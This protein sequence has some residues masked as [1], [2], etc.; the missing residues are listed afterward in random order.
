MEFRVAAAG[1]LVT[2]VVIVVCVVAGRLA[3]DSNHFFDVAVGTSGGARRTPPGARVARLDG[4]DQRAGAR[5]QP[6][7][8]LP[9]GRRPDRPRRDLVADRRPQPRDPRDRPRGTGLRAAARR[10]RAVGARERRLGRAVHDAARLL[11]LPGGR[12]GGG[13]GLAGPA[14]P[15]HHGRR[16]HGPR[17][18]HDPGGTEPARR[19]R[20]VLP[21]LPLAL[22]RGR[23]SRRATSSASCASSASTRRS[24][25]GARRCRLPTCSR[26]TCRCG[27]TRRRRWNRCSAPRGSAAWARWS[28]STRTASCRASSRSRRCAGPCVRPAT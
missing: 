1:P 10:A 4:D 27:S 28:R 12:R 24:P 8:G 9:P 23:R 15:E 13:P 7:P 18:R 20:A 22:V 26:R 14:H 3:T 17:A 21:A 16:H 6:D 5:V 2:L 11:P 25:P 19:P